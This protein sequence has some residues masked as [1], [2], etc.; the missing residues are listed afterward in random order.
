MIGYT[1]DLSSFLQGSLDFG[2]T[3]YQISNTQVDGR[4]NSVEMFQFTPLLGAQSDSRAHS[5]LLELDNGIKI[6]V[7][8]GWDEKFDV[9]MLKEIER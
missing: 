2:T 3:E 4:Q 1:Y 8:I 6:L 9:L 5:S 7:D